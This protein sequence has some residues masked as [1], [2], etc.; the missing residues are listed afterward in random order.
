MSQKK[1]DAYK[2]AKKNKKQIE[3]KQKRN[4]ILAWIGGILVTATLISGVAYL[5]YYTQQNASSSTSESTDATAQ[6]VADILQES[7]GDDGSYT[8]STEPM[9]EAGTETESAE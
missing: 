3:K 2:N 4:K 9:E 1:M 6:D 5:V 8:I 7:L